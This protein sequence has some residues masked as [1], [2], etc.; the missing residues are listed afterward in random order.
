[1]A[2]RRTTRHRALVPPLRDGL[3]P[4]R[5]VLPA[6]GAPGDP[7][8]ASGGAPGP[9]TVVGHLLARF[10]RDAERLTEKVAAGEV[11][12]QLL[13]PVTERTPYRAGAVV[14]LYRDPPAGEPHVPFDVEVL[15]RD[16]NLLVVDKP[17]FLATMPRGSWVTQSVLVRLR[18]ELDLPGLAPAH[19]LDRATAGVLVLTV[20]REAR[21]AYQ[22]LFANRE[23]RKEYAA[24]APFDPALEL[25]ATVRSRILK[26]RGTP[27]AYEVPGEPNAESRVELE[28]VDETRGLAGYRL[29]P[30]TGRTHQLRL[31]MHG[32][33]VPI[34]GDDFFPELRER[35][36]DDFS[37]PLQ[38]LARSLELTDPFTG[39]RRRFVSRRTLERWPGPGR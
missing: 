11:L 15:H 27:R 3:D 17:H 30:R 7:D 39:E 18:R 35:A 31:H 23:V 9:A 19:R 8:D 24:V 28:A 33:G 16:E 29:T 6:A 38:L 37:E 4:T 22:T 14:W 36:P 1:M 10:P 21:G 2:A 25:P 5:V 20:R 13:A 32:L 12:D 34:L 26:V